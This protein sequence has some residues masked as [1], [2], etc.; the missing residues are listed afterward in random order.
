MLFDDF[1]IIFSSAAGVTIPAG[2]AGATV[3]V[4]AVPPVLSGAGEYCRAFSFRDIS[5]TEDSIGQVK[6]LVS[7]TADYPA[8]RLYAPSRN[9]AL[10]ARAYVRLD[11]GA[12]PDALDDADN[13]L[14]L[15]GL[16]FCTS[17]DATY[18]GGYELVLQAKGSGATRAVSLVLRA[19]QPKSFAGGHSALIS[20][21]EQVCTGTYSLGEWYQIR[22]DVIPSGEHSKNLV[23]FVSSDNGTTWAQVGQ[24]RVTALSPVWRDGSAGAS[25]FPGRNGLIVLRSGA[26]AATEQYTHYVADFDARVESVDVNLPPSIDSIPTTATA[27]QAAVALDVSASVSKQDDELVFYSATL[28]NGSPLPNWLV[29]DPL[30]GALSGTPPSDTQGTIDVTVTATNE[31][32]ASIPGLVTLNVQPAESTP[33]SVSVNAGGLPASVND[34]NPGSSVGSLSAVSPTGSALTYTLVAGAGDNQYFSVQNGA[35]VLSSTPPAGTTQ[36]VAWITAQNAEGN[37]AQTQV[38]I[39]V[40]PTAT[41]VNTDTSSGSGDTT[42][43]DPNPGDTIDGGTDPNS[44]PL[45][46]GGGGDL[47][48]G[49]GGGGDDQIVLPPEITSGTSGS[50]RDRGAVGQLAYTATANATVTLTLESSGDYEAFSVDGM[51]VLMQVVPDKIVKSSYTV[52]VVATASTG[53]SSTKQVTISVLPSVLVNE[54]EPLPGT[55]LTLDEATSG[56]YTIPENAYTDFFGGSISYALTSEL[57]GDGLSTWASYDQNTRTITAN[58][59]GGTA[60][61]SSQQFPLTF[62]AQNS[63]GSSVSFSMV[64]LVNDPN[65]LNVG[66]DSSGGDTTP[67]DPNPGD[68]VDGGSDPNSDPLTGGGD[69]FAP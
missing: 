62:A 38:I 13:A 33:S 65:A 26:A 52:T 1:D 12:D 3:A 67:T 54:A 68:T 44:D 40:S 55:A 11:R 20:A 15:I 25:D 47:I 16:T 10:S 29:I 24:M 9:K 21:Q 35:L 60:N 4:E 59:P 34:L 2:D 5:A 42:P 50:V 56:S 14:A 27:T 32:G 51:T 49:G 8:N 22:L 36:L 6:M 58:P 30:T 31:R 7:E 53:F 37:Y 66:G 39:P 48:G 46:G 18:S 45:T 23:A 69:P 19:S 41:P 57:P 64:I 28:S 17:G 43:T 63:V 61:G